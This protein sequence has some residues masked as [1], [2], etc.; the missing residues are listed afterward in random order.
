V[1]IKTT[2][3]PGHESQKFSFQG[4]VKIGQDRIDVVGLSPFGAT[5][6]KLSEERGTG[7]V[8]FESFI[9]SLKGHESKFKEY[10]AVLKL[11]LTA[12]HDFSESFE[13]MPNTKFIFKKYDK[14]GIPQQIMIQHPKFSIDITVTGY[15]I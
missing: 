4:V 1:R 3:T 12:P 13:A 15:D 7:H 8:E 14:S 5:L 6:F 11:L 9:D 2:P 10:Y